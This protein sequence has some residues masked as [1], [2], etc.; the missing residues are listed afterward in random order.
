[1]NLNTEKKQV[2]LVRESLCVFT[3]CEH[4]LE[5]HKTGGLS[6]SMIEEL[7]DDRGKSCLF[8]LKQMCHE[9][10]RNA[11]EVT[12]KEKLY[13]ITVGYIFHEAMKLR[14]YVYQI[15]YYGPEY[16]SL[17]NSPDLPAGEKSVIHEFDNM[18]TKAE[19]RL[20]EGL[21]EVRIL[22]KELASHL[23][24]LMRIYEHNYLL[25]RFILENERA[26][27]AVFGKK[28]FH[29]LV[30][31]LYEKGRV[32]LIFKAAMSYLESEYFLIARGLFQK[33]IKTD[34]N[35]QSAKFL[36]LY[37]SAYNCYFKNKF[38]MAR[39]FAEEAFA[40]PTDGSIPEIHTY[41]SNLQDLLPE[42]DKELG[43][44]KQLKEEKS[45]AYI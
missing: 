28:G 18:I 25:P 44:S 1:M 4:C 10:F 12:F 15:E 5:L 37:T 14:E 8:R 39:I 33:V 17:I 16:R 35:N 45:R 42:L 38:S 3:T 26:F 21:K 29:D 30:N 23:K 32:T 31:S 41:K 7:V 6:F 2:D 24:E 20:T 11:H 19:K 13:D 36:F 27:I 43:K 22:I 40:I 34:Q 9:L